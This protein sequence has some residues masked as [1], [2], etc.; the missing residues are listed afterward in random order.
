MDTIKKW[1][2]KF[3][4]D[5]SFI[6]R[7]VAENYPSQQDLNADPTFNKVIGGT[8]RE[9]Y[10]EIQ[11]SANEV[12]IA[13]AK[14]ILTSLLAINAG[15]AVAV[16]QLTLRPGYVVAAAALF[17]I[18]LIL[19]IIAAQLSIKNGEV[20]SGPIGKATG[21]WQ[22]VQ[23]QGYR[24]RETELQILT[25][26]DHARELRK[27]PTR[28]GWLSLILLVVGAVIAAV[29]VMHGVPK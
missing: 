28:L 1:W 19:P 23:E 3:W 5:P 10:L 17:V 22:V 27:A 14:W 21:Y 16:A 18:G 25:I 20:L 9:R 2:A 6:M 13:L 15:A 24:D 8:T 29:G 12:S 4:R 7:A 26:F 11:R